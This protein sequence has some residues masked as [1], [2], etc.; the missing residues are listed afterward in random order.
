MN[1][2]AS[3]GKIYIVILLLCSLCQATQSFIS[4]ASLIQLHKTGMLNQAL[5]PIAQ[6]QLGDIAVKEENFSRAIASYGLALGAN[7]LPLR[8][9]HH[10]FGKIKSILNDSIALPKD[11][12]W[13]N[14]YH[15]WEE[16]EKKL[17]EK[18]P[19]TQAKSS[20]SQQKAQNILWQ[21][22]WSSEEVNNFK[23][24]IET[25]KQVFGIEGTRTE[26]A[27]YRRALCYY[28][29]AKYDSAIVLLLEFQ[30]KF[31]GS[32]YLLAGLFWQG[33]AHA[34]VGRI[35]EAHKAWNDIIQLDPFDYH[36]HR[37]RQLMGIADSSVA[38]IPLPEY[39]V[40]AWLDSIPPPS[41][42]K[43]LS[44]EDS[45]TLLRG[46]ALIYLNNMDIAA[47]FLDNYENNYPGNLL[48]Q[49]ELAKAYETVGNKARTFRVAR[50]LAW[51]IPTKYRS[52][53]PM[54]VRSII[55]PSYY[56]PTIKKYAKQFDVDSFFVIAVMRQESIFDANIVSGAGAIGLMQVMP[57]TGK[58]IAAELKE[59]DFAADSL[60][61]PDI[62]IRYGVYY[63][64]KR[65]K[66]FEND[67]VL[68]LCA[69]NAGS[70]N[71]IKWHKRHQ[72]TNY[73]NDIFVENIGF[74]ETRGYVKK[75]LGNYWTYKWLFD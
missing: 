58:T 53:M 60:Y 67:Y 12:L 2:L 57:A 23:A 18:S 54:Q 43:N 8:Y 69:Y 59:K 4:A 30:K 48:L 7:G 20:S 47:F 28:K 45:L 31:P 50:R 55:Y 52:T 15:Q 25:Y 56:L 61:N 75:V 13:T 40:R 68:T 38:Q 21:R 73:D 74:L 51:R 29:M 17:T 14:E 64:Q 36:A 39:A 66:Q 6:E 62:A 22:A 19:D 65:L 35:E 16:Q 46:I 71:A 10:L 34:E 26:E 37:A 1:E 49:Y 27:Y 5:A 42:K 70:Q 33:K 32:S 3:H 24:A 41:P 44:G 9:K 72:D 63:L 11:S